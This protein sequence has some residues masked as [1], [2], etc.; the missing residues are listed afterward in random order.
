MPE[1]IDFCFGGDNK[2]FFLKCTSLRL[3][4]DNENFVDSLSSDLDCRI[5]SKNKTTIHIEMGNIL[6]QY[7]HKRI[8]LWFFGSQQDENKKLINALFPYS[9]DF[10]SC[11]S[12][13]LMGSDS[14]TDDMLTNKSAKYL[15]YEYNDLLPSKKLYQSDIGKL[16]KIMQLL[17]RSKTEIDNI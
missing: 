2:N 10:R 16:W 15:F 13:F 1:K 9:G 11:I 17:K 8:Y 4:K 6:W 7:K 14:E 12:E 5:L 3:R